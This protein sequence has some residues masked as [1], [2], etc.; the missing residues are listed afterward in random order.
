VLDDYERL[1]QHTLSPCGGGF[2]CRAC[3]YTRAEPF[4][5]CP[6]CYLWDTPE[7]CMALPSA[8]PMSAAAS[9][10]PLGHAMTTATVASIVRTHETPLPP[11]PGA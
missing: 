1:A 2:R 3:G 5:R 9:T 10:P 11:R 7:R 4:W 8:T 6:S